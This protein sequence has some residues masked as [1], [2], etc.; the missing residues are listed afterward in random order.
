MLRD[1]VTGSALVLALSS[2][3]AAAPSGMARVGPGVRQSIYAP[4]P[5]ATTVPVGAFELDRLPMTNADFVAFVRAV[6][7][8]RRD[9]IARV[10]ADEGY[11]AHWA[12]PVEL[13]PDA[14]LINP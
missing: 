13:G 7:R 8:W 12:G 5:G 14:Q 3:L 1:V 9:R 11:L 10:F 2:V 6:P 4:E